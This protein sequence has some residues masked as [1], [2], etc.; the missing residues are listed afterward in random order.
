MKRMRTYTVLGTATLF[1]SSCLFVSNGWTDEREVLSFVSLRNG[2][3]P[4]ILMD[5]QGKILQRLVI[6]GLIPL[7][8]SWSPD[9]RSF[10]YHTNHVGNFDLYVMD[11]ETQTSRRLTFDGGKDL[12]PAWSPNGKWIAFVSDRTGSRDI[13]RMDVD[14]EN[15]MQLTKQKG[16]TKPAWSPDSQSIAFVSTSLFVMSAN[17]NRLKHLAEA[18]SMGCSWSPDG[19]QIAFISKDAEGGMDI[20][21]I[22]VNGKNLRQLTWLDQQAFIFGTTWAPSGKWIAYVLAEVIG[23]LKP[24]LGADDFAA[25]VVCLI[26]AIDGG[27]GKPI[28]ATRGLV[29]GSTEWVPEAPF[30]VSPN[31]EKQTTLWSRLKQSKKK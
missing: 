27:I 22:N 18:T 23:P 11:M 19:K 13:Y 24:V 9:G 20:F 8:C 21:S 26:N 30:S 5:T 28:E 2:T 1:L 10:A 31:E 6:P 14:G 17:G 4:I 12:S 16:G 3:R 15:L 7:S 29:S 25:P